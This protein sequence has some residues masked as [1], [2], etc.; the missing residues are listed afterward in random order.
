MNHVYFTIIALG[1]TARLIPTQ[2]S[3]GAVGLGSHA[4]LAPPC[5]YCRPS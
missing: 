3:S 5:A 2:V 1:H 4:H